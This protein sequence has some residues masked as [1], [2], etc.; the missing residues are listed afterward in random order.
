MNF[1]DCF[2][3]LGLYDLAGQPPFTPGFEVSG[4]IDAV[5]NEVADFRPGHRVWAIRRFGCYAT[6]VNIDGEYV[7]RIPDGWT[8]AEGAAYPVQAFTAWYALC[9]LGGMP[10]VVEGSAGLLTSERRAV[11]IHSAAGG[12]AVSWWLW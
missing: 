3:L 5:G 10:S 12:W 7:R 4:V 9:E 11:L 1:A 2:A 6:A 8:F